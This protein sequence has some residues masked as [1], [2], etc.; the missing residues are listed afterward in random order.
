LRIVFMG[1]PHCVVPVLEALQ[2]NLVGVV[3]QPARPAGRKRTLCD[4]PVAEW[5]KTHLSTCP[6]LQPDSAKDPEFLLKM[7]TLKPDLVVTASYG[8][9]LTDEFLA[10][11][12]RGTINL[13]PSLLPKH[14]GATPVQQSILEED[15]KTG[16]TILFTVKKMDAGPIIMQREVELT[17]H[18][19]S[20]DLLDQLFSLGAKML[21][22]VMS[23]LEDSD[24]TGTQQD[25]SKVSHCRKWTKEDGRLD[26]NKSAKRLY[27]EH[28]A[29]DPWPGSFAFTQEQNR[30]LFTWVDGY[31]N[32]KMAAKAGEVVI[33]NREVF[34]QCADSSCLKIGRVKAEG[35]KETQAIE[36]FRQK[37]ITCFA[38]M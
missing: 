24:F 13:H 26:F 30:I 20:G 22:E 12:K 36:L 3:S 10:I 19:R 31:V 37:G 29:F 25:E 2:E 18:E 32:E 7:K 33:K 38:S 28:R 21:P 6:L 9:I 16:M 4:P 17:G 35:G 11:P 15:L 27:A 14:R 23:L 8:Q 5:V 34:I 1:S